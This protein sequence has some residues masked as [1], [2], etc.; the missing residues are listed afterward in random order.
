MVAGAAISPYITTT[1]RTCITPIEIEYEIEPTTH[2]I[3]ALRKA[4]KIIKVST[5]TKEDL[6]SV[7]KYSEIAAKQLRIDTLPVNTIK[8]K[9]I[10]LLLEHLS[11]TK[12]KWSA[13]TFNYYRAHLSMLF[14]ELLDNEA[15]EF[16]PV[17][18]IKKQ[19][20]TQLI[21]QVLTDDERVKVNDELQKNN[22]S[23][24]R[25]MQIFFH[26][27]S[28]EAELLRIQGKDV[29]L[30]NQ[31]FKLII[32][33]GSQNK[34]VQK[35]IKDLALPLWTEIM[36][37]CKPTDYV[38]SVGL[39]P[40]TKSIRPEQ[41]TR[42]WNRH[43]KIPMNITAD[44]YSLKHLNL[45]ETAEMLGIVAAADM[46][47]HTS[48]VITMK[49]YAIGEKGRQHI[50]LKSVNNTFVK[51]KPPVETEGVPK[52]TAHENILSAS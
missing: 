40:G 48:T 3:K 17:K 4:L 32:R 43:V 5:H 26:S 29:D 37:N 47:D 13:N 11:R 49:H 9:H 22:Y 28:R 7:V 8:R 42:R 18:D 38:F 21:R 25:F 52:L 30:A 34:E 45:D 41:I 51:E 23:F 6:T 14:T 44:F 33:K 24:W 39:K 1:G 19:K 31:Q 50:K 2:F 36:Q 27:G 46:A 16:N 10:K 12:E 35:T 20:H 15:I